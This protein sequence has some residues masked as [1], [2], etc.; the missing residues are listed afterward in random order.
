VIEEPP[1]IGITAQVERARWRTWEAPAALV[2]AAYARAVERAGGLPALLPAPDP[3]GAVPRL[4]GAVVGRFDGLVLTGGVDIDPARYGATPHPKTA[5]P[6]RDRDA[7]ELALAGAALDTR[8]PTL[9]ICRGMQVLNVACGGTLVQ[10]LPD[11]VGHDRHNPTPGRHGTHDIRL[12]EDSV[13]GRLL[14]PRMTAPTHHHQGLDRLGSGIRPVG[15]AD[16][17]I[18]EAVELNGHPELLAVQWHPEEGDDPRLFE[19][20]VAQARRRRDRARRRE[21]PVP[22]DTLVR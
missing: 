15:W 1:V 21:Q 12:A 22:P 9:A 4:A 16:D 20:L 14:G 3:A 19:W 5:P 7:W 18:V 11:V 2:P 17:G 8:L 13:A 10:H 6:R